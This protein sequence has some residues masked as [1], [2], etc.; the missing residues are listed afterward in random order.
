MVNTQN[1]IILMG[2]DQL[3]SDLSL[4]ELTDHWT[5]PV[6][7][8]VIS[9]QD[10][11][12]KL[13]FKRQPDLLLIHGIDRMNLTDDDIAFLNQLSVS[14]RVVG[15]AWDGL[16]SID[17]CLL[18]S[19]MDL[20]QVQPAR[21]G[22]KYSFLL[23]RF[24]QKLIITSN[25]RRKVFDPQY[26]EPRLVVGINSDQEVFLI[27]QPLYRL[28]HADVLVP[29]G[30]W[31]GLYS[32]AT[33][34][35]NKKVSIDYNQEKFEPDL[36]SDE[37]IFKINA[38]EK[39]LRL[40][41]RELYC[42]D[43]DQTSGVLMIGVPDID[44]TPLE[45]ALHAFEQNSLGIFNSIQECMVI[46]DIHR[47]IIHFNHAF[48]KVFAYE[49]D[50][51]LGQ[52]TMVLYACETK[53]EDM[54]LK[55][56][57]S[58]MDGSITEII[59]FKRKNG[60]PFSGEIGIHP[61]LD[62]ENQVIG[63]VSVIRDIS[64]RLDAIKEK[65]QIEDSLRKTLVLA[66][67]SRWTYQFASRE[68]TVSEEFHRN[69]VTNDSWLK[70]TKEDFIQK[71]V[72]PDDR[73]IVENAFNV[74]LTEHNPRETE[75]RL[76]KTDHS[77]SYIYAKI[78]SVVYGN[79]GGLVSMEGFLQDITERKTT[80]D[81]Y[82]QREILYQ[83][84]LGE[85]VGGF[86]TYD[87]L[88][89]ARGLPSDFIFIEVNSEFEFLTG[90]KAETVL[91]KP[92]ME[93]FPNSDADLIE[94][95]KT[96]ALTGESLSYIQL[97]PEAGIWYD[98]KLFRQTR[99]KV[100]ILFFDV[101]ERESALREIQQ[102]NK[103]LSAMQETT[104]ELVSEHNLSVLLD[105]ILQRAAAMFGATSGFLDLMQPDGISS[106]PLVVTGE[107]DSALKFPIKRGEGLTGTV[108]NTGEPMLI[109]NYD[110][111]PGRIPEIKMNYL[112]CVMGVPL[113]SKG[114]V[115]GVLVL[116]K[117]YGAKDDFTEVDVEIL[118]HFARLATLAIENVQLMDLSQKEIMERIRTEE[119]LIKS[120]EAYRSLFEN[121]PDGVYR[122]GVD[123]K[124]IAANPACLK[125]IGYESF[126]ELCKTTAYDLFLDPKHRD[127]FN[128]QF[129]SSRDI[130]QSELVLRRKDGKQIIVLDNCR[131]V[132]DETGEIKF[133]EGTITEITARKQAEQL[134]LKQSEELS[135][136]Y[137]ASAS[138]ISDNSNNLEHLALTIV[139][140]TQKEF[141]QVNCSLFVAEPNSRNL[142][143]VAIVGPSDN[144]T[145]HLTL[146]STGKGIVSK[147]YRSGEVVNVADIRK[148]EDYIENW[149]SAKSELSLPL[150][151][152]E[153]RLG[154]LDMESSQTD[155][156]S[157]D[158]IR[159]LS[160]FAEKA[161]FALEQALISEKEQKRIDSLLQLQKLGN[162]LSSVHDEKLV[163]E[164]LVNHSVKIADCDAALVLYFNPNQ[165]CL[166]LMANSHSSGI[167]EFPVVCDLQEP[168]L[169]QS[170]L[171]DGRVIIL[172]IDEEA[173]I[174]RQLTPDPDIHTFFAFSLINEG[175]SI[176][177]IVIAGSHLTELSKEE[178]TTFELLAK[179]ASSS[180]VNAR[181]FEST[182]RSL[183]R[184]ASL[185]RID[186][187]IASSTDLTF[188]LD[189]LLEQV[190]TQLG[191]HAATLLK[192]DEHDFSLKF[193]CGRGFK[194]P[195]IRTTNVPIGEGIAGKVAFERIPVIIED[196][197]NVA[198][199]QCRVDEFREEG[200]VSYICVPIIAKGKVKGVLEAFFKE[201][202][203]PGREWMDY[204]ELISG[205]AA[206]A[207][208]SIE[209][210]SNLQRSNADLSL[211]Y[212]STLEGW[213]S[214]LELRDKETEGHTRRVASLT[215]D[216]AVAM[217]VKSEDLVYIRW[218]ALLHDIGKM[219]IPDEILLKPGALTEDEWKIMKQ[220]PQYALD[221][222]SKIDYLRLAL[223]IPYAH[224]EK[225]DGTGYPRGLK[226]DQI[227]LAARFFAV[228]DVWDALVSDRPYRKA[229][230][231]EKTIAHIVEQ[232]GLHFDPRVVDTFLD[233]YQTKR[234]YPDPM[235]GW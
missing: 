222:L 204:F 57:D 215:M 105:N 181:L 75:F 160:I 214:A 228:I 4:R 192:F 77:I 85:V 93:V 5:H 1:F 158:D 27:N 74:E 213:A 63:Y 151:V 83:K 2:E 130:I 205:Q 121:V 161:A 157:E 183:D 90:K 198:Q 113:L 211:A 87:V 216:L 58:S 78:S 100:S 13:P 128:S 35:R 14:I 186:L 71:W 209:L 229:W 91:G 104:L 106:L 101:T 38:G 175:K 125:I 127:E 66:R 103:Y 118:I 53:F 174:L 70:I 114:K 170:I 200:F 109:K 142:K 153:K 163:L 203:S 159:V 232:K 223:D 197:R 46:T 96:V 202:F 230:S 218:G 37:F 196:L 165:T 54:G 124:F 79:D 49:K 24:L 6:D 182:R 189:I 95:L 155:A 59:T 225:W 212:D 107:L 117:E 122:T 221:M 226:E 32:A 233:I 167:E 179:I 217:G 22:E 133:Y 25:N 136:L 184:L 61:L 180:I 208:E 21:M 199:D 137:R 64:E 207:I 9:C 162:E 23:A 94:N 60:L 15:V 69:F 152:G 115:L 99:D 31:S 108:W 111:W 143:R 18:N 224:H 201:P 135:R 219:A 172:N 193:C 17:P 132:R 173:P 30:A 67:L 154:V 84:K 131:A 45:N 169:I 50:E 178:S 176:G 129:N 150:K 98:L 206:I 156:F 149:K 7:L 164:T 28:I 140:T 80:E 3:Q 134:I 147:A 36:G 39:T 11:K 43:E 112:K 187:A 119:Q 34:E 110:Q 138:L 190:I 10:L 210:F 41:S 8:Q 195:A 92:I 191:L 33:A 194:N 56:S 20:Y 16:S 185:R 148:T 72:H 144:Y 177:V 19:E 48:L 40:S 86:V 73:M 26:Q 166:K 89:D 235:V 227:P 146:D 116:G 168:Q 68:F 42:L 123:G 52:S 29:D 76:I 44:S 141:N 126:E 139:N 62:S 65:Q 171:E 88:Y 82:R 145:N 102:R 220:H 188:T 55:L 51:I 81:R 97:Y 231:E 234:A 120:E 12:T 47:R